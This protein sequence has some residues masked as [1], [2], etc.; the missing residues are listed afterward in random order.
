MNQKTES[1][2]RLPIHH[3]SKRELVWL[4]TH[5][6]RHGHSYLEHWHCFLDEKPRVPGGKGFSLLS[7]LTKTG[8]KIGFLDI[9]TSN[10]DA[11]FGII[12]T[13]AI[14]VGKKI[15][16]DQITAQDIKK[17]PSDKT[18]KR[19]V[20][21]LVAEILKLDRIVTHYGRKFDIPFIRTR[22]LMD[23]IDFPYYGSISNDD[24]W[25][26]ARHKLKL[27]SNRQD[28]IDRALFGD[29]N[30]TRVAFK[31][32]VGATTGDKRSIN[33]ILD[34]NK[35]DVIALERVWKKL[36]NFVGRNNTSI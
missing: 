24:T 30:K 4:G 18:D 15:I 20:K 11:N 32:W 21:H 35:R 9:E 29:T 26:I 6:C 34:H 22:A 2:V 3:L 14:K 28:T 8:E 23:G 36:H 17:Y 25:Y 31:Y 16:H 10:L 19:I 12:L 7:S 33:Y 27:N 1:K 5:K 13:W